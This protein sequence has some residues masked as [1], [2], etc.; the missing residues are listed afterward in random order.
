MQCL[1]VSGAVRP[2]Y[3][4]LGVKRLKIQ[5]PLHWKHNASPL[6]TNILTL[7]TEVPLCFKWFHLSNVYK[8]GWGESAVYSSFLLT[9]VC[10]ITG[11]LKYG[12]Y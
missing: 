2:I 3:G 12:V 9:N 7:L 11:R 4:S 5:F 6:Q 1:E 8:D 10:V